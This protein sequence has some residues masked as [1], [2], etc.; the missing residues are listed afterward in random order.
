MP[1]LYLSILLIELL[2]RQG[3]TGNHTRWGLQDYNQK[4]LELISGSS[5]IMITLWTC[6]YGLNISFFLRG[7]LNISLQISSPSYV[8]VTGTSKSHTNAECS[9][10]TSF[11]NISG[12]LRTVAFVLGRNGFT[13]PKTCEWHLVSISSSKCQPGIKA[14][15]VLT[16]RTATSAAIRE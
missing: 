3:Q 15:T 10:R 9:T 12:T 2:R 16:F 13:P 7:G 8:Q 11:Y 6:W 14:C 5:N 1:G 4:V